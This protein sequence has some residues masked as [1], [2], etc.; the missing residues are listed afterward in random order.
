MSKNLAAFASR[1]DSKSAAASTAAEEVESD[2]DD[3]D[4]QFSSFL[5][6]EPVGNGKNTQGHGK[7]SNQTPGQSEAKKRRVSE[8]PSAALRPQEAA[9]A[10]IPASSPATSAYK[11]EKVKKATAL[12]TS[13]QEAFSDNLLWEGKVRARNFAAMV[14]AME[15][16]ADKIIGEDE[17]LAK[18]MLEFP[19]SAQVK[20]DLFTK[21][22]KDPKTAINS[23]SDLELKTLGKVGAPLLSRMFVHIASCLIKEAEDSLWAGLFVCGLWLCHCSLIFFFQL[24]G[25]VFCFPSSAQ[26]IHV[27]VP[28]IKNRSGRGLPR[29]LKDA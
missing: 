15:D 29:T 22:K 25:F 21:L 13:K 1:E 5:P 17:K 2:H 26:E 23:L 8:A 4:L 27:N 16:G 12:F 7:L 19:E 20:F 9:A 14:K 24:W 11:S 10:G 18:E 6:A 28:D 3:T